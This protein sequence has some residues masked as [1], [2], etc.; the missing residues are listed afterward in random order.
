VASILMKRLHLC[1]LKSFLFPWVD[2]CDSWHIIIL[3]L[4][5]SLHAFRQQ[6][7]L[8]QEGR[9]AGCAWFV[10]AADNTFVTIVTC[11]SMKVFTIALVVR[12]FHLHLPFL[13]YKT[14]ICPLVHLTLALWCP[15]ESC[16]AAAA[17]T[18]DQTSKSQLLFVH[19]HICH[20]GDTPQCNG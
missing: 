11:T 6:S 3:Q 20:Y 16:I 13:I 19:V 18:S 15:S 8:L 17:T 9:W 12:V 2:N 4:F 5:L 10:H 14:N 7:I 1:L